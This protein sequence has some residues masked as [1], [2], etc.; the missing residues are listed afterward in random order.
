LSVAV[1][2]AGAV[3]CYFGGMLA[4]GGIDVTLIGRKT[5]MDAIANDGLLIDGININE[6]I[7]VK[8]ATDLAAVRGARVILFCVKTTDTVSTARSIRNI[9]DSQTDQGREPIVIS[10]QNGVDNAER[11]REATGI[12]ALPAAVYVAAMMTAPGV[13]KHT[14]RGDIV[15][16]TIP[17]SADRTKDIEE[18]SNL[19]TRAGVGCRVSA[20]IAPEMWTKLVINCAYNAISARAAGINLDL[21]ALTEAGLKLGDAMPGA[22]SSTAQDIARGKHTEIDS[23][24]GFVVRRGEDLG[25]PTPLNAALYALVKRLENAVPLT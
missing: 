21:A 2:G 18:V 19:F 17:G 11:I 25:V 5:H 10:M 20:D 22:V 4:R 14:G 15:L 9:L 16:G 12:D 13:V 1:V 24:N 7:R 6:R 8:T 23:L 3:G